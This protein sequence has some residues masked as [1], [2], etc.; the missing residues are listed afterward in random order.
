[1]QYYYKPTTPADMD[2]LL[3][4]ISVS[5]FL[6]GV[7]PAAYQPKMILNSDTLFYANL[8]TI[9][10]GTSRKTVH[11]Y[12]QSRI[13]GTWGGRLHKDY[14]WPA[15]V[16]A[17]SQAGRDAFSES[18][19]WR[20]CLSE[21]D[22]GLGWLLSAAFV[23]RA[24]S[25]DAKALGDRIVSDI[26]AEFSARLKKLA[27]MTPATQA[28]AAKKV[29]NIIQKI[30]YPTASPNIVDPAVSVGTFSSRLLLT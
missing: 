6:D 5:K 9:L 8:S 2:K 18:E 21:V 27:W 4:A 25:Q 7:K 17:N 15:K 12:M 1:M 29:T 19:R 10:K 30:G 3:P 28:L 11:G 26:K 22:S 23:E 16:F 20:T 13:I 14:R 24:F